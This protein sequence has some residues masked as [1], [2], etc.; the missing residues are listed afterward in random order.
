MAAAIA[1]AW[2]STSGVAR[3]TA[4]RRTHTSE[5]PASSRLPAVKCRPRERTSPRPASPPVTAYPASNGCIRTPV[6][7]ARF[8]YDWVRLGMSI[9]VY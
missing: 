4:G 8:I 9:Y 7:D 5:R 2:S 3:T 1:L 6:P